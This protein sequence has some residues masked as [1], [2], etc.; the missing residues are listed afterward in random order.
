[1]ITKEITIC[2]KQVTLGYCFATSIE[3]RKQTGEDMIDYSNHVLESYKNK[4][5]PDEEK[6]IQASLASM[7]AYYDANSQ[8]MPFAEKDLKN[9]L[10]SVEMVVAAYTIVSMRQEFYHAPKGD[11]EDNPKEGAG[12]KND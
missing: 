9:D 6:T 12:Q 7:K 2:G 1:M 8:E 11:T 4:H 10:D 3:Y 5:D